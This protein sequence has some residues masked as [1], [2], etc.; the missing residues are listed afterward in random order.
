MPPAGTVELVVVTPRR[1]F[2]ELRESAS[3]SIAAGSQTSSRVMRGCQDR[4]GALCTWASS[5]L[6][7]VAGMGADS[8]ARTSTQQFA[9]SGAKAPSPARSTS[10]SRPGAARAVVPAALAGGSWR[11]RPGGMVA[12]LGDQPTLGH[13][14]HKADGLEPELMTLFVDSLCVWQAPL[15]ERPAR[16]TGTPFTQGSPRFSRSRNRRGSSAPSVVS[17]ESR[18]RSILRPSRQLRTRCGEG[19]H[20]GSHRSRCTPHIWRTFL[21]GRLLDQP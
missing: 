8:W 7:A 14:E 11:L 6:R 15:Q 16:C 4:R 17:P 10:R 20:R 5:A 12:G 1:S 13:A 19:L 9:S 21:P 18:R 2:A 3:A